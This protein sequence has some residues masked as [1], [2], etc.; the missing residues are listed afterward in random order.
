MQ[1]VVVGAGAVGSVVAARLCAAGHSVLLI[2]RGASVRAIDEHGLIVEGTGGGT[3]RP[4][5]RTELL[6]RQ[7][8]DA[9]I[10]ATKTFDLAAAAEA[11]GRAHSPLPTLLVQNGLGVEEIALG[12]LGDAGW[13]RPEEWVVR[14][15]QSIPATLLGPG[16][17][18]ATGI[19]EVILPDPGAPPP[20]REAVETFLVLL[21]STGVP[22]RTSGG[23]AREVWRKALVNAAINP[24]T[25]VHGVVNGRLLESPLREEALCLLEEARRVAEVSGHVFPPEEAL[26]D[27]ERV[28]RAS[29]TN[30]SSMLQDVERGRP[31]EIDAISGELLA[32]GER[33]GL[34][35]P[36]TRAAIAAVRSRL[37]GG[38]GGPK[39]L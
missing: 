11:L 32:R 4:Q 10:L 35:L 13:S 5:A 25:A 39:P 12:A 8:L 16:V 27:F 29:A 38:P 2:G 19:G 37:R 23:L 20:A 6:P 1:V 22:L 34:E 14:A 3:Y 28:V 33:R 18:R 17:V 24:V 21:R 15:V 9:A 31:T 30:R 36:A 7:P 26:A